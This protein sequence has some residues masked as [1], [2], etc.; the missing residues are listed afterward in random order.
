MV[1]Q[2]AVSNVTAVNNLGSSPQFVI[3]ANPS[4]NSLTFN[5]PGQNSVVVF[6]QYILVSGK[7]VPLTPSLSA[8]GGGFLLVA[9]DTLFIG[10]TASKQQ[11]Q[12]LSLVGAGNPLTITED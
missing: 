8:L 11:W 5:N 1:T 7:S 10:S 4:R 9:G 12:A 3:G 2:L 6:P